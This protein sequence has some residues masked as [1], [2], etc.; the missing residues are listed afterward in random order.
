MRLLSVTLPGEGPSNR[1]EKKECGAVELAH[2]EE[3]RMGMHRAWVHFPAAH[4]KG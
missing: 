4:G 3:H 2:M 1:M